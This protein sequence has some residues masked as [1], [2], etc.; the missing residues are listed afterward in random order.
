M[1]WPRVKSRKMLTDRK[2]GGKDRGIDVHW[3][4]ENC[5]E[6]FILVSIGNMRQNR[7]V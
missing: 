7:F 1:Y 6:E 4:W 3:S 2:D 5:V